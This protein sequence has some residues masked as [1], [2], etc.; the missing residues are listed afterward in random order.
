MKITGDGE[1]NLMFH[2]VK[3]G[4]PSPGVLMFSLN[5]CLDLG[6]NCNA[7]PTTCENNTTAL[8]WY[9][10]FNRVSEVKS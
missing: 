10:L 1:P 9:N 8:N 6:K 5:P 3:K 7:L 2:F 4:K